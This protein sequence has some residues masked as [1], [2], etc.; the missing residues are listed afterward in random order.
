MTLRVFTPVQARSAGE[1]RI[2][3][4]AM[5]AQSL[6]ETTK[7]LILTKNEV[8]KEFEET[9]KKKQEE[10]AKWFAENIEKKNA[11]LKEVE[12]IEERRK[13]SLEPILISA[14]DIHNE[15][16][17]LQAR[18]LELDMQDEEMQEE[19]RKLT[20]KMDL[21][22]SKEQDLNEREKRVRRVELG[23]ETQRNQVA[24]SSRLLN[25]KL[26]EFQQNIE[27]KDMDIAFRESELDARKN[28]YDQN[29]QL[30]ITREKEIE[31]AKRLLA[32]QRIL[33]EKGFQELRAKQ[34]KH[35]NN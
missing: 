33:L 14:D 2:A 24:E 1:Q 30:L 5:R 17:A 26:S 9:M 32:D 29:D 25:K 7:E 20:Q 11:L 12:K 31:S 21:V 28:L 4:D 23:S 10:S 18:K 35:V 15:F 19:Y 13:K 3:K 16:E 8:E 22:S 27:Q 34:K 6:A